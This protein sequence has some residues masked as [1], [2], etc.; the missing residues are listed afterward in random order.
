MLF[1]A[2]PAKNAF[3]SH[4][5]L[6]VGFLRQFPEDFELVAG[7]AGVRLTEEG[8]RRDRDDMEEV[9]E[10]VSDDEEEE[11]E[12]GGLGVAAGLPWAGGGR[13]AEEIG[14]IIPPS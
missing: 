4:P 13:G 12:T 3:S 10:T 1:F 8:R 5:P 6:Q 9:P 2:S 11:E 7:G 14:F